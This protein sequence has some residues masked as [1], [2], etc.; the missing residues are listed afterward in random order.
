MAIYVF[1]INR[2]R[3]EQHNK[4]IPKTDKLKRNFIFLGKTRCCAKK[5][6]SGFPFLVYNKC[7][8]RDFVVLKLVLPSRLVI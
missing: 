4:L 3:Q 2:L 5:L 6:Y 8:Q 1:F 7:R